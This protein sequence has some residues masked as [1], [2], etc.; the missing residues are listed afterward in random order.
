MSEKTGFAAMPPEEQRRIASKGGKSV[1]AQGKAHEFTSDE[2]RAAGRKGGLKH[3]REHLS[4]I[5]RRGA[6]SQKRKKS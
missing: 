6:L 5:G 3:S 1:H 4:E 2:A